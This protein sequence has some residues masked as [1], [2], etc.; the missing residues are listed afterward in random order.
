MK[1]SKVCIFSV[2]FPI[3]ISWG[4]VKLHYCHIRSY[5]ELFLEQKE[6][7]NDY[8]SIHRLC[9][10]VVK[11]SLCWSIYKFVNIFLKATAKISTIWWAL[12]HVFSLKNMNSDAFGHRKERI[13]DLVMLTNL[14]RMLLCWKSVKTQ[15]FPQRNRSIKP[16]FSKILKYF[17]RSR[18]KLPKKVK[19]A[20]IE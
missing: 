12:I 15:H 4:F 19:A 9:D 5:L 11:Y 13:Y 10:H 2:H 18:I 1:A 3:L 20:G 14:K 6:P 16:F 17:F 8:F 7:Q